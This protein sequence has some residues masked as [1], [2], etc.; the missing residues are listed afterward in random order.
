MEKIPDPLRVAGLGG[1]TV[2]RGVLSN[3]TAAAV[4]GIASFLVTP[5]LIHRMGDFRYGMWIL[6]FSI[7]S[8]N[9][10]LDLGMR[11]T[12]SRFTARFSGMGARY[13]QD[14]TF[15]TAL[16]LASV[17]GI[18]I[19]IV[20]ATLSGALARFFAAQGSAYS[21]FRWL[22]ILLGT[23]V[24]VSSPAAAL[25]AYLHG[26][27]RFE[28]A[29][30]V[31]IL[32]DIIRGVL[33]A[34]TVYLGYG[35]IACSV[36]TLAVSIFSIVLYWRMVRWADPELSFGWRLVSW[37]RA[38][39]MFQ[40]SF[41]ILLSSGGNLL[42]YRIDS[43]VIGRVLNLALVTPY[44]V[45]AGL[46]SYFDTFMVSVMTPLLP[47]M[48]SLDG[49]SKKQELQRLFLFATKITAS[50]ALFYVSLVLLDG[51]D[52][53]RLWLGPRFVSTSY[54][55]LVVLAV[56]RV[57]GLSQAPSLSMLYARGR[58][59]I[60]GWWTLGE[61]LANLVLSV[62]WA[63]KYG[64]IGVA[65][66]TTIPM[67]ATKLLLQPWYTL[68]VAGLGGHQYFSQAFL[69]PA[70]AALV[71]YWLSWPIVRNMHSTRLLVFL[72]SIIWQIALFG[73]VAWFMVFPASERWLLWNRAK[74]LSPPWLL[75]RRPKDLKSGAIATSGEE[76]ALF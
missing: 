41:Y 11:P 66:G 52:L 38:R 18:V 46:T 19:C 65:W 15:A 3:W 74:R 7:L 47:A 50:F 58:H 9:G 40:F 33:L 62:Y 13:D 56:G 59:Q 39:Q 75:N 5:V 22:L 63:K 8:Y 26:L 51:R 25:G 16:A 17:T 29:N 55:L 67:L 28:L 54:S 37:S 4:T 20:S 12:L 31:P 35:V 24:G 45:A 71:F 48:S 34:T 30:L 76:T 23:S 64:V 2:A 53:L 73:A 1:S 57:A 36:V 32:R 43:I 69:R 10:L 27:Q 68:R 21:E 14:E 6:V 42:R 72:T 44:N 49:L 61:G 60:L 70:A